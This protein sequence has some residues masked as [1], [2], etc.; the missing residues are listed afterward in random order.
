MNT[1]R[2]CADDILGAYTAGPDAMDA[3]S[4]HPYRTERHPK[5][6]D[7]GGGS[8]RDCREGGGGRR[9][10]QRVGHGN[11]L[12]HAP[13]QWRLRRGDPGPE[14]H[15]HSPLLQSTRRVEKVFW[16]DLKNDGLTREYNEHNFGLIHHQQYNCAPKPGIVAMS[17]FIRLTAGPRG[18]RS[19]WRGANSELVSSAG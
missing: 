18:R 7:L 3:W 12:S 8:Q 16:Y 10:N 1:A 6:R 14:L 13:H 11:R 2:G 9:E 4:I 19:T 5:R 15:P 17:V